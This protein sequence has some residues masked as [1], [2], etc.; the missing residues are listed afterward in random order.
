MVFKSILW[1]DSSLLF[2]CGG[3]SSLMWSLCVVTLYWRVSRNP[4]GSGWLNEHGW[5]CACASFPC[6]IQIP[7][8]SCVHGTLSRPFPRVDKIVPER[9]PDRSLVN[10][11]SEKTRHPIHK[12]H[13]CIIFWLCL[14]ER[15]VLSTNGAIFYLRI[16]TTYWYDLDFTGPTNLPGLCWPFQESKQLL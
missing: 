5:Q 14:V 7:C 15:D 12:L 2:R 13:S 16:N 3:F 4:R 11:H 6:R 9:C 10:E 8:S 1:V